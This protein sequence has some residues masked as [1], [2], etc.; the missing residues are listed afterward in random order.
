MI[1]WRKFFPEEKPRALQVKVLDLVTSEWDNYDNF[2]LELPTGVGKSAIAFTL[3]RWRAASA[4]AG[5]WSD[6][7]RGW[8]ELQPFSTYI[9][10]ASIYLQEVYESSYLQKGLLKLYSAD[11]FSCSRGANLT[12]SEGKRINSACSKKVAA[13]CPTAC[14]YTQA[15]SRFIKS[16]HGVLNLAYYTNETYYAGQLVPR[17]IN[18]YDE[19]HTI[20]D[21]IKDFVSIEITDKALAG[22]LLQPPKPDFKDGS[23]D[24][25]K[26]LL[27]MKNHYLSKVEAYLS[28]LR[29]KIDQWVGSFEDPKFIAV[30]SEMTELDKHACRLRRLINRV[31][32]DHWVGERIEDKIILTPITPRD[33]MNEILFDRADKNVFLSATILD[34]EFFMKENNLDPSRTLV[35]KSESPFPV[36]NRPIYYWPVGKLK[37]DNLRESMKP[38]AGA[39]SSILEEHPNE[40]GIIFVSSYSQAQEL[41]RQVGSHRLITHASSKDKASMMDTHTKST[42][43]VIVSPSMHEGVDLIGDLSRFQILVKLPFPSLGSKS[44]QVRA[45]LYPEWYAYKTC[46]TLI[47]AT[48]RS[49]RSDT[50][51]AVS[52][53]LDSNFGWFS[54][55]W[56]SFLPDY[57]KKAV[58]QL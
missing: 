2:V 12:C 3:A 8:E 41:I 15:K 19:A 57:W 4:P 39:V 14:P 10:T 21:V 54:S 32:N 16:P 45:D 34:H 25:N 22:Y 44:I 55:R 35:F 5:H 23:Y 30:S 46:L 38:F 49:I 51:Y 37:H 24:T 52:Y 43:T 17:H 26:L 47:Q 36:E 20:G 40:R 11:N 27:W 31:T 18:I 48:G 7:N 42:N 53:I 50:D 29:S 13:E 33:F 9:T 58:T 1:D 28:R 6:L 56:D